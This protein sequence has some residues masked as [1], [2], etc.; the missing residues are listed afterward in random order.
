MAFSMDIPA[1]APRT[2]AGPA[3]SITTTGTI[4]DA[5]PRGA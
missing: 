3:L 2:P 4:T 5:A 1:R